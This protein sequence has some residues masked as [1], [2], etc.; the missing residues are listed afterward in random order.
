MNY[1]IE[2]KQSFWVVGKR[3]RV[4]KEHN[5]NQRVIPAFWDECN[6]NGVSERI[7]AFSEHEESKI[8]GAGCLGIC[9]GDDDA[10]TFDYWIAVETNSET[11][12]KE[13]KKFEI[14]ATTWAIFETTGAL[15]NSLQDLWE[16]IMTEFL[17]TSVYKRNKLLDLKI[18]SDGNV[19]NP[20]YTFALWI[21]VE[22]K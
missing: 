1:K 7:I 6:K 19:T 2:T 13:F 22:K 20:N 8:T 12:S 10:L 14:P 15:P 11:K 5:E 18:Y 3:L 16:Y 4:S 21:P 9:L 17:P